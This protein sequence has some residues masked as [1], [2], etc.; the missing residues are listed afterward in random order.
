MARLFLKLKEKLF[1]LPYETLANLAKL[2]PMFKSNLA[3][4]LDEAMEQNSFEFANEA[5]FTTYNGLAFKMTEEMTQEETILATSFGDYLDHIYED[6]GTLEKQFEKYEKRSGQ[7]E[8]SETVYD[9]FCSGEH[10]LIEAETGTGKS[11]AYLLPAV[12]EAVKQN[13]RII[14]STHT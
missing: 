3:V 10:A 5:K 11:L 8:M 7:R 9:A 6:N 2:E 13:K 14:I 1:S 4:L 12:Y